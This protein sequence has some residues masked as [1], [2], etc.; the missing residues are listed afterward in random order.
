MSCSLRLTI[1]RAQP[2]A[3]IASIHL[4][5]TRHAHGRLVETRARID[6]GDDPFAEFES[7]CHVEEHRRSATSKARS[8]KR[9]K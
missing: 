4:S 9:R 5:L 1:R 6:A 3:Q 2:I 8:T 7:K